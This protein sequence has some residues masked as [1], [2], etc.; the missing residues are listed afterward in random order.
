ML[1][2]LY[3]TEYGSQLHFYKCMDEKEPP[4]VQYS[5]L[6]LGST[7]QSVSHDPNRPHLTMVPL[8]GYNAINKVNQLGTIR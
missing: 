8:E 7:G 3:I 2:L 6:V 4:C 1:S 5:V